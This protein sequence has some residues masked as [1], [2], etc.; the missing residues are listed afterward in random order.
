MEDVQSTIVDLEKEVACATKAKMKAEAHL[1][2]CLA[3]NDNPSLTPKDGD[4]D[5]GTERQLK[6]DVKKTTRSLKKLRKFYFLQD[7]ICKL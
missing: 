2:R 3:L 5:L 4:D 7:T 1:K 6:E